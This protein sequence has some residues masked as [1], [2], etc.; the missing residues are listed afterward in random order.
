MRIHPLEVK[1]KKDGFSFVAGID[2]AG[3]GPWAGPLVSAAVILPFGVRIP[4]LNDSK[5][6]SAAQ[7]EA[8]FGIILKKGVVGI[9]IVSSFDIDKHGLTKALNVSYQRAISGLSRQPE[10]VLIDGIGKYGLGCPYSTIIKGDSKVK[11]I[12][13]AS[14]VAKVVRDFIMEI[15]GKKYPEYGFGKHKG[16]GTRHHVE[17]LVKYG[18][19]DIHRRSFKPVNEV[20]NG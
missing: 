17:N 19:C 18:C 15:Y 2:E 10:Y 7:R 14:V 8:L 11:S 16:Y 20:I 4:G 13:A 3:R 1:L 9:G 5:K 6:L 12:A